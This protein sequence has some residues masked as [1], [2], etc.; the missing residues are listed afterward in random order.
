MIKIAI[1]GVG[2]LACGL[3]QAIFFY[4]NKENLQKLRYPMIGNYKP[5]DIK[6]VAA[7][8]IDE[9]KVGKDLSDAIFEHPSVCEKKLNINHLGVSVEKGILLDEIPFPIDKDIKIS[10]Q[11]SNFKESLK[12]HRPDILLIAINSFA[13]NSL[14]EYF[15]IA[16]ELGI[17]VIN[18]TPISLATND[19]MADLA[20]ENNTI[21]IGD[22][23]SG[24]VDSA[25]IHR[26][27]LNLLSLPGIHLKASYQLDLA[28]TL[29]G[30]LI[31]NDQCRDELRNAR[32]KILS[33]AFPNV[34]ITAGSSDW[35]DFT[36][37]NKVS[38]LWFDGKGGLESEFEIDLRISFDETY[39]CAVKLIDVIRATKLARDAN[40]SGVIQE[41]CAYGFKYTTPDIVRKPYFEIVKAFENLISKCAGS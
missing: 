36:K 26:V 13:K 33:D 11:E 14:N 40:K 19:K 18:A 30:K 29:E 31:M 22:E 41:I 2:N 32:T 28:D 37:T 27:L 6:I 10:Q 20:K 25:I 9:R 21:L 15:K 24:L 5:E 12:K 34:S 39:N 38:Y 23:I 7:Y 8:D 17:N 35:V 1:A 16:T 4:S 3:V